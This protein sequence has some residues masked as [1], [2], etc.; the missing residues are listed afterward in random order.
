MEISKLSSYR[1]CKRSRLLAN[2]GVLHQ[3]LLPKRKA[4]TLVSWGASGKFPLITVTHSSSENVRC[5]LNNP[6]SATLMLF[7][8][9]SS[10]SSIGDGQLELGI[11]WFVKTSGV[12]PTPSSCRQFSVGLV[13]SIQRLGKQE[14]ISEWK[15][16]GDRC[17]RVFSVTV[18]VAVKPTGRNLW[19]VWGEA[20]LVR[21]KVGIE[22]VGALVSYHS[23]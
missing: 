19:C 9:R 23:L 16:V 4:W 1:V 8:L 5:R 14:F 22:M 13:C 7:L 21:S 12:R 10:L 6:S 18:G 17:G 15:V 20:G 2:C 3:Q 11:V